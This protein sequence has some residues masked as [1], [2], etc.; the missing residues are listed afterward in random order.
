MVALVTATTFTKRR[1]TTTTA[2]AA[3]PT[4]AAA[5]VV[6]A[7]GAAAGAAAAAAA[8]AVASASPQVPSCGDF[9]T[10]EDWVGRP[11]GLRDVMTPTLT[12][13]LV[14]ELNHQVHQ[15]KTLDTRLLSRSGWTPSDP[16]RDE[17]TRRCDNRYT[18]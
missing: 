7:A 10:G 8:V 14:A 17:G 3:T 11:G 12:R 16:S 2:A 13:R 18:S 1:A 6:A 15:F 5:A 4:A 9:S